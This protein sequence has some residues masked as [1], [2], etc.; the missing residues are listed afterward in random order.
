MNMRPK[1]A[2]GNWKMNTTLDE[3][4]RL[5]TGLDQADWPRDVDM[6]LSVP[7]T[8]L[9]GAV[10]WRKQNSRI[11]IGAQNCYFVDSGAYTGE[12]SA[13]MIDD[14]GG[15]FVVLG[16]SERREHFFET[17]EMVN[18]K[19]HHALASGL[20]VILCVGEKLEQRESE[21]H[22][23]VVLAQLQA[24]LKGIDVS[25]LLGGIVIAYEPV[26]AIG[27]GKTATPE[28]AQEMHHAIRDRLRKS[29]GEAQAEE[30][31]ILY[32]GSV[33]PANAR[34]LFEQPDIDGGLVGG[35][36]LDVNSFLTIANSL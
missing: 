34:S 9:T 29:F 23:D 8:H 13:P 10:S 28:Q 7:F 17:N 36:S 27:T 20:K 26:W 21:M 15:Q 3:A 31:P 33:K 6:W 1:I 35:A 5:I 11:A 25:E 18:A 14:A 4:H 32:G 12:I 2:A 22:F 16:H 19:V 30:I 24:G